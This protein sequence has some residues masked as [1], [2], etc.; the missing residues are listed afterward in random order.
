M[1]STHIEWIAGPDDEGMRADVVLG[2]RVEG[3]SRRIARA[4]AR[5]GALRVDD[6]RAPPSHRVRAG[7]RLVLEIPAPPP[8]DG[9]IVLATTTDFVYVDKPPGVHTHRLRPD[10]P[11]ALADAVG[12][13]FPE[14]ALAS[15]DPREGGALHRLDRPTTGVTAFARSTEAWHRGRAAVADPRARKL[16]VALSSAA[17]DRRWPSERVVTP[18]G[19]AWWELDGLPRPQAVSLLRLELPLGRGPD[20]RTVAVRGDGR[21]TRCDVVPLAL[22]P[23]PGPDGR[24]R[25]LFAV[26]LGRGHRH[27]IRVHLAWLGAPIEGDGRYGGDAGPAGEATSL[28]LHCA[29]LDLSRCCPGEQRVCAAP[30]PAFTERLG[31][32]QLCPWPLAHRT[33]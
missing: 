29:A 25:I 14:C 13:R 8:P 28:A 21:P 19:D 17:A 12:L 7:E 15:P 3:L 24:D 30:P 4:M 9:L 11:P 33:W 18:Q 23:A 1:T 22:T 5:S 2:G 10:D 20:R 31:A 16:Y 26:S 27:Q 32:L 6:R